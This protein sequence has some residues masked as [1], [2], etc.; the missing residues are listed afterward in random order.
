MLIVVASAP[1]EAGGDIRTEFVSEDNPFF[2]PAGGES[3]TGEFELDAET[4]EFEL[5]M[6]AEG[7][8]AGEEYRLTVTVRNVTGGAFRAAGLTLPIEEITVGSAT[9]DAEGRLEFEGEGAIPASAFMT[10][11]EWRIDQQ[12]KLEG[13]VGGTKFVGADPVCFECILT[14]SPTTKVELV[15]GEFV[16]FG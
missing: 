15:D 14:C 6:D 7:L 12:V 1:V 5:Q 11:T 16:P 8:V 3:G 10:G 2:T 13:S 9:A 4:L